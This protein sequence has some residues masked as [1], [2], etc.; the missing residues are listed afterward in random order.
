MK[1]IDIQDTDLARCVTDA[2]TTPVVVI[3]DGDPV[4]LVVGV[5]GL[6]QEQIEFGASD[7]FWKLISARRQEKTLSRAALEANLEG[8]ER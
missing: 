2:Q 4:A 7:K 8:S 6:D 5:Q 3:R 1:T